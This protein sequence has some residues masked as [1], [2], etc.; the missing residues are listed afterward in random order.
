MS[1]FG[2]VLAISLAAISC[3][4]AVD[5]GTAELTL[6]LSSASATGRNVALALDAVSGTPT[7]CV[8]VV[9]ACTTY[10][11]DGEATITMGAECPLPLGG[12][13]SGSIKIT[14]KWT[15]AT[16]AALSAEFINVKT[17]TSNE[18]A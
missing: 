4:G 6:G 10:P 3:G 2:A 13:A 1:R 18:I 16:K 7:S 12:L 11:C 8:Q 5:D 15:S 9:K 17:A 14:G